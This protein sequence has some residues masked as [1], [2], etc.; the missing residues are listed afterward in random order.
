VLV[1]RIFSFFLIRRLLLIVFS[2]CIHPFLR[3][4]M[5]PGRNDS[6]SAILVVARC[7]RAV[8]KDAK[9]V[10]YREEIAHREVVELAVKRL[11]VNITNTVSASGTIVQRTTRIAVRVTFLTQEIVSLNTRITCLIKRLGELDSTTKTHH[12]H[13]FWFDDTHF[14]VV[15]YGVQSQ[16]LV[17]HVC[18]FR[19]SCVCMRK[20]VRSN[21]QWKHWSRMCEKVHVL[22]HLVAT[23]ES[24]C[25]FKVHRCTNAICN[26]LLQNVCVFGVFCFSLQRLGGLFCASMS[27]MRSSLSFVADLV[28]AL[29]SAI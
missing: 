13:L 19:L 7:D 2:H 25:C 4:P 16:T 24:T 12:S 11:G 10:T 22:S 8:A 9:V 17:L 29:S 5:L 14:L 1:H 3:I 6:V 27:A 20:L 26:R 23:D 15:R 18:S 28:A 21:A